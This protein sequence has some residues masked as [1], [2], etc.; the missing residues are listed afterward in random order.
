MVWAPG[1]SLRL[2]ENIKWGGGG[3]LGEQ[4]ED[5][6]TEEALHL[7]AHSWAL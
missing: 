2:E 1:W 4:Q 3:M 6:A 7:S 5:M